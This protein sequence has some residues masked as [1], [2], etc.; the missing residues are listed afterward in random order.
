M[1]ENCGQGIGF[2][3]NFNQ[4]IQLIRFDKRVPNWKARMDLYLVVGLSLK[5]LGLAPGVGLTF[6]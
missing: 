3:L 5:H 1:G 2:H 6:M 4:W